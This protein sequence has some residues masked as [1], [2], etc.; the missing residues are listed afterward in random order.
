M[1]RALIIIDVQNAFYDDSWGSR[2]NLQAETNIS[3]L[4]SLWRASKQNV[5]FIQHISQNPDS[6]FYPENHS[7]QIKE[8]V[9]P[10]DG[11]MIITKEVNSA[12]INT[13]LEDTL[14]NK[15]ITEVVITGLTTPHCVSTTTRMSGNLGFTTFLISDATAAFGLVDH[16]DHYIDAETIHHSSLATLHKEFA[17][18]ITTSEYIKNFIDR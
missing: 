16:N 9:Q 5:I 10:I 3:H 1:K 6:L 13:A 12:F 17:T 18:V 11:E 14:K 4:L 2:N 7:F 8:I 15:G